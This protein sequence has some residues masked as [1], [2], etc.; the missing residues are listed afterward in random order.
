MVI[1]LRMRETS[2]QR[3]G[4]MR[5]ATTKAWVTIDPNQRNGSLTCYIEKEGFVFFLHGGNL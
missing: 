2:P 3:I 4:L 1:T 5:S